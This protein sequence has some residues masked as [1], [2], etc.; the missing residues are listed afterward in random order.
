[1]KPHSPGAAANPVIVKA[2]RAA[3]EEAIGSIKARPREVLQAYKE[4]TGDK[5]S[6]EDLERILAQPD[7]MDFILQPQGTMKFAEHLYKTGTL[8]TM[9]KAW[10]DYRLP[11]ADLPGN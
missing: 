11:I 6:L 7:M 4:I 1:M 3:T 5:A 2:V 8:K 10:T 9:P